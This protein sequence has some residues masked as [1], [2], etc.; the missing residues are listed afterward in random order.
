MVDSGGWYDG[1]TPLEELPVAVLDLETT[2]LRAFDGDAV[3]E[4]GVVAVDGF[5]VREERILS[6]LVDPG[7]PVSAASLEV[8]G[9]PDDRLAGRPRFGH[10][11]PSLREHLASR[12]LVGHNV[13]FDIGFLR[14]EMRRLG[15][16]PAPRTVL[17][18]MMMAR[19]VFDGRD[20]GNRGRGYGL[21][22]V[23]GLTGVPLDGLRRHRAPD[24]ALLTARV[25]VALL[26]R[27]LDEGAHTL[28][29]VQRRVAQVTATSSRGSQLPPGLLDAVLAA[30]GE[31]RPLAITY[32]APR[33]R[34]GGAGRRVTTTR[35][36]VVPVALRGLWLDAQCRLRGELR[37]FRLDR[38]RAFVPADED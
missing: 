27:L 34:G 14:M 25:Y 21:D 31:R 19:A 33:S 12:A 26:A 30:L 13:G 32:G 8:H 10:V 11:L 3:I 36:E 9:I 18:T 6:Q 15:E 29:D 22:D 1:A 24:D 35:R 16:R 7:C 2:G 23:L 17:D 20:G 28:Q 5:E 4:I 37:T 38:I